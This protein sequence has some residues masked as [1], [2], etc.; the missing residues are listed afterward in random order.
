MEMVKGKTV[1]VPDKKSPKGYKSITISPFKA[2]KQTSPNSS[3]SPAS[4]VSN[5]LG[6]D[7]EITR[8]IK[9]VSIEE[10][11]L[12]KETHSFLHRKDCLPAMPKR[13][14]QSRMRLRC[15]C[16]RSPKSHRRTGFRDLKHLL[17][18]AVV[19]YGGDIDEMFKTR[20]YLTFLEEIVLMYA[21]TYGRTRNRWIDWSAEYSADKKTVQKAIKHRLKKEL[22]CRERWPM[23][24]SYVEDA[25]FRD[26]VWNNHFDPED[27]PRPVMHDTT[28]V[29]MPAP[30]SGDMNWALHNACVLW[31]VLCKRRYRS[32]AMQLG[33]RIA[34]GCR[35]L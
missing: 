25:K 29:E 9:K 26:E 34:I 5:G 23:Y 12:M 31:Y 1:K 8:H 28:N 21:F 32:T 2:P 27:G 13:I 3:H 17:S 22:E 4:T 30:S 16:G 14:H 20:T 33:S 6:A 10:D 7:R 18:Y 11:K 24:A 35:S 19:V 15:R